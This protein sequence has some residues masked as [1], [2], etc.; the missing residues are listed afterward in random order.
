MSKFSDLALDPNDPWQRKPKNQPPNI[1]EILGDI[2]KSATGNKKNVNGISFFSLGFFVLLMIWFIS[3]IYVVRPAEEATVLR[4]GRYYNTLG[5]GLH[6]FARGIEQVFVL[7]TNEIDNYSYASEMLTEDENYGRVALTVYYRIKDPRSY[8]FNVNDPI[9]SLQG[10]VQSSLR[11]I[12]G[13]THLEEILTSGKER[14]RAQTA[15][16]VGE[17]LDQYKTGIEV[18]DVKLQEA[19]VPSQVISAFDN[20]ITAREEKAAKISQGERYVKRVVPEAKGQ[21]KRMLEA[22]KAYKSQVIHN[23]QADVA[24]FLALLPEYQK[25]GELMEKRLFYQAMEKILPRLNKVFV[26]NNKQVLLLN[27]TNNTRKAS[28]GGTNVNPAIVNS[29]LNAREGAD[30]R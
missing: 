18:T 25:D 15:K 14:A 4:F 23:A 29:V 30:E 9:E 16:L 21:A 22:G 26:T 1:D 24:R 27:M 20:V 7:N 10:A 12:I 13:H 11:Q 19:T 6:W 3:G 8:L 28:A 5:P 17:I 2:L